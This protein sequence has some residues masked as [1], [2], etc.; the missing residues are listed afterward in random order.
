M[1]QAWRLSAGIDGVQKH[2]SFKVV[3]KGDDSF[4]ET[5]VRRG[6]KFVPTAKETRMPVC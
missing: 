6:S 3:Y 1:E 2:R 5:Y 4:T